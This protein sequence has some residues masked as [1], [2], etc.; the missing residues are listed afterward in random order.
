MMS[1]VQNY[2]SISGVAVRSLAVLTAVGEGCS[3]EFVEVVES[4][5]MDV[6]SG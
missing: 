4:S 5:S 2:A 3:C 1:I 6:M